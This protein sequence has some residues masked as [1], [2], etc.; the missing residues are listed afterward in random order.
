MKDVFEFNHIDKS[1]NQ[2]SQLSKIFI[3]II[4]RNIGVSK[5][6][7]KDLKFLMRHSDW[8]R[9]SYYWYDSRRNNTKSN[10]S[11]NYKWRWSFNK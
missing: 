6:L 1:Q 7:S 2:M 5:N 9:I 8:S 4:T 3:N 11:R 10:N